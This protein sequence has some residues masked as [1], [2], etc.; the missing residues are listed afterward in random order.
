[1]MELKKVG[2]EKKFTMKNAIETTDTDTDT[3]NQT[4]EYAWRC[5]GDGLTWRFVWVGF[6]RSVIFSW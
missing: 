4:H 1:M 3:D 2:T 6:S 5:D